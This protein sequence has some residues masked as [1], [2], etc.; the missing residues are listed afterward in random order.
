MDFKDQIKQ[1]GERV[2]KLK[3]QVNTEEAT[4]N[5]FIMPF[6]QCLGYDVFNPFEVMPEF[7]A[8]LGI[9]QGEKV[10]YAIIH[11]N[12]PVILIE[13][14][15]HQAKLDPHNSQL[16][17]YF[18][19]TTA[20]FGLLTNGI[21]FRFY[22]DLETPNKMDEKPFFTFN[23][24]DIKEQQISEL[25]KFHKAYYDL[26]T[27][28]N[29]AS[30]LKYL[31]EIRNLINNEINNPSPEFIRYFAKQAYPSVVTQKVLDQFTELVKKSFSLY[32]HDT[33]TDKF[34][35]ALVTQEQNESVPMAAVEDETFGND[36]T[37]VTTVEEMEAYMIVKSIVRVAVP[38]EKLAYRD[39][40]SYFSVLFDDN[41]RKPICRFHFNSSKKYIT[42][43]DENKK[44]TKFEIANLDAIYNYCDHL[45]ATAKSY[46]TTL[47]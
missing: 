13:C 17:R 7:T 18:H 28:V 8:D 11:N 32:I 44:E 43:F 45:L 5:A 16:F 30:E 47:A 20:K 14:K 6:L 19:T 36:K 15:S 26:D 40:L 37:I 33:L 1:L 31:G 4:K 27:I 46:F 9:K 38:V 23:I 35:T 24:T 34:K 41:N 12:A 2:S 22:T 29:T 3:D 25:K 42:V 21:E 10:D 39:A